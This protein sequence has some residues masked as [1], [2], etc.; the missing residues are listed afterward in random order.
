MVGEY[1]DILEVLYRVNRKEKYRI[2][3]VEV[4]SSSEGE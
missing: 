3:V 1:T 2:N 4:I